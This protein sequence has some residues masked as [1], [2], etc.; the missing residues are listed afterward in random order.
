MR[1]LQSG[2]V[3]VGIH[4]LIVTDPVFAAMNQIA[5]AASTTK[6]IVRSRMSRPLTVTV[7]GACGG[8][9]LRAISLIIELFR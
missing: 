4:S 9:S 1:T 6:P 2:S 3:T 7:E 5:S 8:D